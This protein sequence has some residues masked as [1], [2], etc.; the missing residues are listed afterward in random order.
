MI[1]NIVSTKRIL[2]F[3]LISVLLSCETKKDEDFTEFVIM[4]VDSVYEKT[5]FYKQYTEAENQEFINISRKH[6]TNEFEITGWD[7]PFARG[8]LQSIIVFSNGAHGSVNMYLDENDNVESA[9]L[10]VYK[11]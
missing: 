4:Y 10:K 9:V 2:T 6:M 5:E 3:I 11:P 1:R 8:S 7:A